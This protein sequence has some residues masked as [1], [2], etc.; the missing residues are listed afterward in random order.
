MT[1]EDEKV[2]NNEIQ[3]STNEEES[4]DPLD[5]GDMGMVKWR[6]REE[7]LWAVVVERRPADYWQRRKRQRKQQQPQDDPHTGKE[8][9]VVEMKANGLH[10]YVHYVAHDR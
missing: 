10:Y 6:G 8:K 4:I 7:K 2:G 3:K 9:T 1:V 5:I